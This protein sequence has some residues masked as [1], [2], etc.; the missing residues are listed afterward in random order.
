MKFLGLRPKS[1]LRAPG[2]A[3]PAG[4]SFLLGPQ[5]ALEGS[6]GVAP[7]PYGLGAD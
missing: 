7:K 1:A 3:G 6:A 4:T 2:F 5:Q